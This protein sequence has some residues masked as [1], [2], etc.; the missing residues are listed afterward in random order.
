MELIIK[1]SGVIQCVYSDEFD[2]RTL[3]QPR[4]RRASHVE[5]NETGRWI[6]DLSPVNGPTLGPFD[7]RDDA[8]RA[9]K[10]Y[11]DSMLCGICLNNPNFHKTRTL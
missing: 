7:R 8:L 11:L 9:E 1:P 5:P 6:A 2:F 4:I 10:E 3:G